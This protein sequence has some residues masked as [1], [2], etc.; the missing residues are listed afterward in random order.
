MRAAFKLSLSPTN[1][2]VCNLREDVCSNSITERPSVNN[3][4]VT[5]TTIRKTTEVHHVLSPTTKE[6][7]LRGERKKKKKERERE[8]ERERY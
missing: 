6:R 3:R 7:N 1:Y 2:T 5:T 4:T 8:I